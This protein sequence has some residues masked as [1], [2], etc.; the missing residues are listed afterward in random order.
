VD[1]VRIEIYSRAGCHLCD[2]AKT[3]VE[4]VR[5][6]IAFGLEVIDIDRDPELQRLYGEEIPVVF[7]NGH[8]AFKYHVDEGEFEKRV[9]RL[10]KA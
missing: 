2:D 10:W 3:V 8:K 9:K 7:I 6:R 4:R 1:K 5:R